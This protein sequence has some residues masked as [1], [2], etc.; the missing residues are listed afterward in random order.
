MVKNK[1]ELMNFFLKSEL[2]SDVLCGMADSSKVILT[3]HLI[4]RCVLF[5]NEVR[6]I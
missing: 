6:K 5:Q 1:G 2:T 3:C 4:N